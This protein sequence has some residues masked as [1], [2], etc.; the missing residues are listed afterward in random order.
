MTLKQKYKIQKKVK[1]HYRKL[2]K[3]A[4]RVY[5]KHASPLAKGCVPLRLILL[6]YLANFS[7]ASTPISI[8][9]NKPFCLCS[10]VSS[11]LIKKE[12]L[13]VNRQRAFF[14]NLAALQYKEKASISTAKTFIS[15][16]FFQP[17]LSAL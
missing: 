10:G 17:S 8:I 15:A 2:R 1:E 14:F 11:S 6:T 12:S 9:L 5:K 7:A 13:T 4:T 3:E 16:H